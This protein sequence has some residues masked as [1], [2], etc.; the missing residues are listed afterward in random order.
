MPENYPTYVRVRCRGQYHVDLPCYSILNGR[1]LLATQ[2]EKQW[3]FNDPVGLSHWFQCHLYLRGE[4]L[5]RVVRYLKAWADFQSKPSCPMPSSLILTVFA[6]NYYQS[7][8]RDDIAFAQTLQAIATANRN[9]L[10]I[11]NPID[12]SHELTEC[13]TDKQ[14]RR[15]QKAIHATAVDAEKAV[16]TY[17]QRVAYQ[18]WQK[19][20]G[21]RFPFEG[22]LATMVAERN[23]K[24]AAPHAMA[25]IGAFGL[26]SPCGMQ[27]TQFT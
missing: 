2:E 27:L 6:T 24:F 25:P 13:L 22:E 17:D 14:K 16:R 5:K 10:F 15:F 7:H 18:L 21:Q 1:C 9:L 3:P 19:H 11:L 8:P 23:P 12:L 4:Q 20:L 26:T